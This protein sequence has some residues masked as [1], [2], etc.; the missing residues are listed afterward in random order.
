M[1]NW[2]IGAKALANQSFKD[3]TTFR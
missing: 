1:K 3:Q 2:F